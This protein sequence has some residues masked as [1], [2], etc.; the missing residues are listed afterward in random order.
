[1][2]WSET[3][4]RVGLALVLVFPIGWE[5][6]VGHKPAGLRTHLLVSLGCCLFMLISLTFTATI[7][8]EKGARRWISRKR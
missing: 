3:L 2:N 4:V 7:E 8:N 1:M 6:E 5:R